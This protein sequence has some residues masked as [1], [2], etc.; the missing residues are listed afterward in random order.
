MARF[1]SPICVSL[2]HDGPY[3][4]RWGVYSDGRLIWDA[5]TQEQ[6][7]EKAKEARANR[8]K[9]QEAERRHD[10]SVFTEPNRWMRPE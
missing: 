6:A 5:K 8:R 2:I 10:H 1:A 7:E 4:G 3:A 9:R